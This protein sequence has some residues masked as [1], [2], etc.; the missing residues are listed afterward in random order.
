[1]LTAAPVEADPRPL[2]AIWL[3]RRLRTAWV[4]S[5]APACSGVVDTI[6][7]VACAPLIA[8]PEVLT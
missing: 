1:V 8:P 2:T 6:A 7:P 3:V 4:G 5:T